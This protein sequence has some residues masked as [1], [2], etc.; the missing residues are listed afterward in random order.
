MR[1]L[2]KKVLAV[3]IAAFGVSVFFVS[4]GAD[5]LDLSAETAAA[6]GKRMATDIVLDGVRLSDYTYPLAYQAFN[7]KT[8]QL[9]QNFQLEV[10][11][12]GKQYYLNAGDIALDINTLDLLNQLWLVNDGSLQGNMFT[13]VYSFDKSAVQGFADRIIKDLNANTVSPVTAAA[14]Q[15]IGYDLDSATFLNQINKK[16]G[17]AVWTNASHQAVLNIKSSPVYSKGDPNAVPG[18]AKLGTFTTY[19]TNVPNRNINIALA[20]KALTGTVVRPGATF[21]FNNTLGYTSEAKGYK[22]AG[23]LV[24]GQPDTGLGGGICQVSSTLYNAVLKAGMKIVE[25]HAH[26]AEVGYVPK[27]Q[28][29]TVNYGSLDFKFQNNTPNECHLVFEYNNRTLT[30]SVYGKK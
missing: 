16:I 11:M 21:S 19:T 22:V 17:E 7:L 12:N 5:E 14:G 30:V 3:L 24:N 8:Q 15:I 27:G 1:G 13:S 25:R 26:S 4:A 28:D 10:I 20:C 18:Y 2:F 29:A 23:I 9:L 6:E